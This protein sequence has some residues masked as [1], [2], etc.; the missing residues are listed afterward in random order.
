MFAYVI[1]E[2]SLMQDYFRKWHKEPGM[3]EWLNLLKTIKIGKVCNF[4]M[5]EM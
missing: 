3:F 2:R 4:T 5:F 1:V